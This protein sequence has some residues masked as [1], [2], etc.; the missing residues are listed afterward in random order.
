MIFAPNRLE[1]GSAP[2]ELANVWF[3][4]FHREAFQEA[5]VA[6]YRVAVRKIWNCEVAQLVRP[7][8]IL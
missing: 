3:L 8:T 7:V 4:P 5:A 6:V 2:Y 1:V